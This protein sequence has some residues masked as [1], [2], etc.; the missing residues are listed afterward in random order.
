M[1]AKPN[2]SKSTIRL[3]I[4]LYGVLLFL[5]ARLSDS[6]EIWWII[7]TIVQLVV[8]DQLLQESNIFQSPI[9]R[10]FYISGSILLVGALFILLHFPYGHVIASLAHISVA[11][12]YSYRTLQKK[13]IVFLDFTK[14]LWLTLS[15]LSTIF[16]LWRLPYAQLLAYF[17]IGSFFL[18]M[19]AFFISDKSMSPTIVSQQEITDEDTLMDQL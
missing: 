2:N 7:L 11:V 18:M 19:L 15:L 8:L 6:L 9:I 5:F 4:I 12:L 16:T 13:P 10:L 17:G 1:Q 3:Y 14:W